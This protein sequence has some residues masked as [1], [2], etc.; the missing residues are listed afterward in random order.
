MYFGIL[1]A[2]VPLCLG[3][4]IRFKEQKWIAKINQVLS[5]M[6]YFILFIMGTELAHLD[7]LAAN[8][9]VI[10]FY[11]SIIFICT[12]GGNFIFLALIDILLPWRTTHSS[13]T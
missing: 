11:T 12:F 3:Y 13:Q 5:W 4:L 7:N 6:V 9:K 10:L 2:L 8:L 1:I